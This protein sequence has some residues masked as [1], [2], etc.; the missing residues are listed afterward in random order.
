MIIIC[1]VLAWFGLCF[2][3]FAGALVW[4][5]K[6]GKNWVSGRSQCEHCGHVLKAL[7]LVPFFSW[8]A[9]R[10]RCRY[11]RRKIG[12]EPFITEVAGGLIFVLSYL[13][14]PLPL[15]NGQ[16][17]LLGTWLACS[18]GLLAL[19]IYDLKWMILPSEIVYTTAAAAFVG[20]IVYIIG[21]ETDRPKAIAM[22]I[23][24]LGVAAGVF[25]LL[26]QIDE[27]FIGGGDI[28]LGL[29][30]GTL[31]AD[32]IKSFLMIF[33]ASV[34]GT[35]FMVPAVMSK[36]KGMRSKLPYGPFLIIAAAIVLF[37]GQGIIDWY[38]HL[39]Y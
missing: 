16:L 17:V 31:L 4:R 34:L 15:D 6:K 10:G 27:R 26:Y 29:V 9:L 19:L 2:G 14:W 18:V 3:S 23:L 8:L 1:I 35:A 38:S 39:T 24:S 25:W 22:W 13:L 12:V 21:Y 20:R 36:Q 37:W 33:F 5:I 30:T 28:R 7:D 32:P 11:C